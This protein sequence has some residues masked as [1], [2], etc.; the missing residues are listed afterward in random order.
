MACRV[1]RSYQYPSHMDLVTCCKCASTELEMFYASKAL[2]PHLCQTCARSKAGCE[3]ATASMTL[4]SRMSEAL[5]QP[6]P[7]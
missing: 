6:S 4:A 7:G 5:Y 2:G 3:T 1:A